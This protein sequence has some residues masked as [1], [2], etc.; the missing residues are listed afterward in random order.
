MFF[1]LYHLTNLELTAHFNVN[2]L[3][4]RL[5]RAYHATFIT[6]QAYH[7]SFLALKKRLASPFSSSSPL[8]SSPNAQLLN[9]FDLHCGYNGKY[10]TPHRLLAVY[11]FDHALSDPYIRSLMSN[12]TD[13]TF[14]SDAVASI[15]SFIG[16][17]GQE[18]GS[19][20]NQQPFNTLYVTATSTGLVADYHL[21]PT[22]DLINQMACTFVNLGPRL[23]R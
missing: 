23:K 20:N 3:H 9:S 16:M 14:K 17:R 6:H 1:L 21:L 22:Q 19:L 10:I 8:S 18:V 11:A 2:Q 5:L 13:D 4:G 15:A 7:N 12:I